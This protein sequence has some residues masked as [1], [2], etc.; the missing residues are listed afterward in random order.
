MKNKIKPR[1]RVRELRLARRISQTA[2][3]SRAELGLSTLNRI[4]RWP[5]PVSAT[6]AEKLAK[7]L[8]VPIPEAFPEFEEARR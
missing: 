3:A 4:E 8:G 1:N 7:A 6:T 2:L 5:F